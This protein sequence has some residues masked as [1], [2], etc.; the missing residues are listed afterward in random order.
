ML[1]ISY[2]FETDG[3]STLVDIKSGQCYI[4]HSSQVCAADAATKLA[5]D[6]CTAMERRCNGGGV[7]MCQSKQ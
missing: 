7:N 2:F 4:D 6:K 1:T 5:E 3:Q